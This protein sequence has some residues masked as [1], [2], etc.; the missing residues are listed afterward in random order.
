MKKNFAGTDKNMTNWANWQIKQ[1][2][3]RQIL[4]YMAYNIKYKVCQYVR[5]ELS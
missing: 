2:Q 4:L 1:W 5:C 3:I